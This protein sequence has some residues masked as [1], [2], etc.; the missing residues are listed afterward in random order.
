MAAGATQGGK[1]CLRLK[2]KVREKVS[3]VSEKVKVRK[4]H[5]VQVWV[6]DRRV[7]VHEF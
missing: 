6:N 3:R 7:R 2:A 5:A 1:V 4:M